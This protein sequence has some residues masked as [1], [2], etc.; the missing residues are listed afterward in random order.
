[1][2]TTALSIDAIASLLTDPLDADALARRERVLHRLSIDPTA[3]RLAGDL[4]DAL[5]AMGVLHLPAA[6]RRAIEHD[7]D[8]ACLACRLSSVLDRDDVT[9]RR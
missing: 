7:G 9:P 3:A 4:A 6:A 5:R 8:L 1:M 2:T